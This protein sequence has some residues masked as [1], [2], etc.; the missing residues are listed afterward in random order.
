MILNMISV[1]HQ[2]RSDIGHNICL[3]NIYPL[4]SRLY[5]LHVLLRGSKDRAVRSL[6][7]ALWQWKS[8]KCL[9]LINLR[10]ITPIGQVGKKTGVGSKIG[11]RSR[12]NIWILV[13]IIAHII[14]IHFA[15]AGTM[16]RLMW[17]IAWATSLSTC[18]TPVMM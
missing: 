13:Q 12:R 6:A 15:I 16:I 9:G 3:C 17:L 4:Y 5:S 8:F 7:M 11:S 18:R 14:R 10:H 2:I 1:C